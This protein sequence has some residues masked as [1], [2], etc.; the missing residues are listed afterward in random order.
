M[1]AC[2]RYQQPTRHWALGGEFGASLIEWSQAG[3]AAFVIQ[4]ET[5]PAGHCGLKGGFMRSTSPIGT[6]V[7]PLV[8]VTH[9]A[10]VLT[11]VGI[12]FIGNAAFAGR[13]CAQVDVV[14]EAD[15]AVD[16]VEWE[17]RVISYD[18]GPI[19]PG[20][21]LDS[22]VSAW[23]WIGLAGFAGGY[24]LSLYG[25]GQGRDYAAIPFV[26]PWLAAGGALGGQEWDGAG[27]FLM[28]LAGLLQPAGVAVGIFGLLNPD[29]YLVYDAPTDA[30]AD[31]FQT[32]RIS[33]VPGA[34]GAE[35][36]ASL[37]MEMF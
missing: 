3:A 33:V 8:T 15:V 13:A 6:F 10:L 7:T 9:L 14:V 18:G 37:V 4:E 32:S 26:G 23:T 36:G 20:A 22:R 31:P 30:T 12:A 21:Q 1:R 19:R 28:V 29:L 27:P 5:M 24:A 11:L 35:L 2:R 16:D 34:A 25:A 17:E